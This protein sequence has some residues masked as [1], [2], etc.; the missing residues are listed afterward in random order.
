RPDP[1]GLGPRAALPALPRPAHL[2]PRLPR[3]RLGPV[4][5]RRTPPPLRLRPRRPGRRLR[6]RPRPVLPQVPRPPA[7][8]RLGLRVA[9]PAAPAAAAATPPPGTAPSPPATTTR[10]CWRRRWPPSGAPPP[11]WT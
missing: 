8:H 10:K 6:V 2:P 4:G 5:Q 9:G 3:L 11:R 1:G 7:G